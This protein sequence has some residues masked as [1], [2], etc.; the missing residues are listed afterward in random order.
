LR[1]YS[2]EPGDA[3]KS[4]AAR[5]GRPDDLH[6]IRSRSATPG[7]ERGVIAEMLSLRT[8]FAG[9]D[10]LVAYLATEFPYAAAHGR[11]VSAIRGG[12]SAALERLALISPERYARTRRYLD[13]GVTHLG[14]YLRH[15]LLTE[16]EVRDR[17]LEIVREP[18]RAEELLAE[19]ARRDYWRRIYGRI[20]DGVWEDLEPYKTGLRAVDY[21]WDLPY[22]VAAGKTGHPC[23]DGFVRELVHTGYLHHRARTWFAAWLVH[24][25]RVRWQAGAQFFLT[26][27]L[28]GDPASNNL[29]WQWVASTFSNKPYFFNRENLQRYGGPKCSSLSQDDYA[30]PFDASQEALARRLFG[31]GFAKRGESRAFPTEPD[32]PLADVVPAER[33]I[34]WL[35]DDALALDA[36]L[37]AAAPAAPLIYVFDEK[38]LRAQRWSLKR[39]VFAFESALEAGATIVRGPAPAALADFAAAHGAEAVVTRRSHDPWIVQTLVTTR[40]P[41]TMVDP[42]PFVRLERKVDLRR[43]GPY[44]RSAQLSLAAARRPEPRVANG[45][46][47]SVTSRAFPANP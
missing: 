15:G 27:L 24:W 34:V 30:C 7:R 13:G 43:F 22:D 2:F 33:A 23:I 29:S 47:P 26:H 4:S 46:R 17:I 5:G 19:L 8:T 16:A 12:R 10:D 44:W 20:G 3:V 6:H 31:A 1:A 41:A 40:L 11:H 32:P 37:A 9:R 14:P 36:R 42:E 45:A 38:R 25:R 35:H 18:S 21:E 39:I 28:D